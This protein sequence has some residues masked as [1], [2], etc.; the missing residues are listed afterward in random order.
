MQGAGLG[1]KN[2]TTRRTDS[3]TEA[4]RRGIP[5]RPE[6]RAAAQ[7]K[8]G[9]RGINHLK[10]RVRRIEAP[11][12]TAIGVAG[13]LRAGGRTVLGSAEP[14]TSPKDGEANDE[15]NEDDRRRDGEKHQTSVA[16]TQE[17]GNRIAAKH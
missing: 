9:P 3:E 10:S 6:R 7:R 5:R 4:L 13:A 1:D 14:R 17:A 16:K 12:S 2:G 8:V 11:A 15:A